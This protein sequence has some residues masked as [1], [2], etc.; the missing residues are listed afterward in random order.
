MRNIAVPD[1]SVTSVSDHLCWLRKR[2]K[3]AMIGMTSDDCIAVQPAINQGIGLE[4]NQSFWYSKSRLALPMGPPTGHLSWK[5]THSAVTEPITKDRTTCLYRP[6]FMAKW[7]GLSRQVIRCPTFALWF[8]ICVERSQH[9]S[10]P[11]TGT[12]LLPSNSAHIRDVSWWDRGLK[13]FIHVVLAAKI[14]DVL[15]VDGFGES[16][17]WE[18]PL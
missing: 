16:R 3:T 14:I 8:V 12:P 10:P 7:G 17:L 15:I 4:D 9:S 11:L 13:A 6:Q 5:T 18:G 1:L 2:P